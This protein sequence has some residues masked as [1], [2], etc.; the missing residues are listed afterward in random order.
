MG[1]ALEENLGG[2]PNTDEFEKV[3]GTVVVTTPSSRRLENFPVRLLRDFQQKSKTR[4][5]VNAK[6]IIAVKTD[7]FSS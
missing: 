4:N 3:V 1:S 7:V 5:K 2:S 6:L